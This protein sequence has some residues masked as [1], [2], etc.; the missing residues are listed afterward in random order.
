MDEAPLS[1]Q[2]FAEAARIIGRWVQA[3]RL[4]FRQCYDVILSDL[5]DAGLPRSFLHALLLAQRQLDPGPIEVFNP[6][7]DQNAY[8]LA[9]LALRDRNSALEVAIAMVALGMFDPPATTD[10]VSRAKQRE[11]IASEIRSAL[12]FPGALAPLR[13]H[14]RPHRANPEAILDPNLTWID[15]GLLDPAILLACR[16]ICRITSRDRD[17]KVITGT[18]FLIGP[19]AVMTNWHVIEALQLH[20]PEKLEPGYLKIEFDYLRSG[21]PSAN[22]T[23]VDVRLENWLIEKS[24]MGILDPPGAVP[25]WWHDKNQRKNWQEAVKENL[26]FAVLALDSA[27]GEQRGWYDLTKISPAAPNGSCHVFHHPSGQT[28]A[29]TQGSIVYADGPK[30][31][32]IFHNVSTHGG[33]SGGLLVDDIGV[34]SALHYAGDEAAGLNIA[35]PLAAIRNAI[36]PAVMSRIADESILSLPRGSLQ[37]GQPVFGRR[38]LIHSIDAVANGDRR[39]L[40][41]KPPEK[42]FK[43]PGKTFSIDILKDLRPPPHN[44]YIELTA[45]R[46][47]AGGVEMVE[48]IL[49]SLSP[50]LANGLPTAGDSGTTETAFFEN[51]LIDA[52]QQRIARHFPTSR[53]WLIIDDLDVH[54]LPDAGGRRFL[55]VLYRRV[56]DIE[57]LR[58]VLVGLKVALPGIPDEVLRPSP[59][60]GA[61]MSDLAELVQ[62]WLN[63]RGMRDKPIGPKGMRLLGEALVS[64]AGADAPLESLAKITRDHLANPL[65]AYFK[66]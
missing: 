11:Q 55:D 40:W 4:A 16:R 56:R 21:L 24:E 54:S 20:Y 42:S 53:I 14:I 23:Q 62:Q 3:P 26:D 58:I 45:D 8:A 63:L 38:E 19:S 2:E 32:R 15:P 31:V 6:A 9:F 5:A 1:S 65:A 57:Q 41:V 48:L 43:R 33:S 37:G 46:V 66:D 27:P 29:I 49:D 60:D 47:R 25:G 39:I 7:I 51:Q 52:L 59:I 12:G 28:M 44:L 22:K 34:P 17:W 61:E 13:S 10:Q 50:G 30:A 35:I 64:L 18:G 36:P